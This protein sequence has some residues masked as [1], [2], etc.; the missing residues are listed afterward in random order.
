MICTT[1]ILAL[2]TPATPPTGRLVAI[3][4]RRAETVAN[5]TLEHAVILVEDGKIA[6]IGQDLPVE[7]GIR[8]VDLPDDWTVLPGLVNAYSRVG[9]DGE[10]YDDSHPEVK[11]SRLLYPE[12]KEYEQVLELGVTTLGNYPAGNGI[13]GQ[14]VAVR[15]KGETREDM[16]LVDP[17]Y[18]KVLLRSNASSKK[19]L[20]DG[21]GK[22]DDYL[23][24]ERKNRE[25]WE[26]DQEKKKKKKSSKKKDDED[27]EKGSGD[28]EE[29]DEDEKDEKDE[30]AD[31]EEADSPD[32]YVPLEPDPE[33]VPF[34]ALRDGELGA[35][36]GITQAGD[37]E[38]LVDA[39]GDEEF[40]WDLRIPLRR[41]SDVFF[42]SEKIGARGCRVVME[43]SITLQP[44]T[45]RQ[46]NLPAEFLRAGAKLV[47]VPRADTVEGHEEWRENV[48]QIVAA[49]LEPQAALRAMTLEPAALLGL[50]ERVGS[51][52]VGKD[53]NLLFVQ[54]DPFEPAS[55]VRAVMLEGELVHGD[56]H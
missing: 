11:T 52:E 3:R 13:P 2:A 47:L 16:V 39:I 33:V 21:F 42:V 29:K 40:R 15:P 27:D 36:I 48:G 49:G 51:L 30:K 50:E 41:N 4:A 54:G 7:R 12:S 53:A 14:A 31:E 1:L 28:D 26:K 44:G 9:L 10:G 34:M 43:P 24:K 45:M 8:V 6:A 25:K 37:Y 35:L 5:G 20:T 22:V 17:A 56:L 55:R 38:H 18:L 32:E 23:E 19:M 46:R